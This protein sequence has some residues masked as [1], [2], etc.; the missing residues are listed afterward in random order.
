MLYTSADLVAL[1]QEARN[2][3]HETLMGLPI[4]AERH[5]R[6]RDFHDRTFDFQVSDS[7]AL[8]VKPAK[9]SSLATEKYTTGIMSKPA[10]VA[11]AKASHAAPTTEYQESAL[12]IDEE[13]AQMRQSGDTRSRDALRIVVRNQRQAKK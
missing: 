12:S 3:N 1:L 6:L 5:D 13:V 7:V 10:K 2:L 11:K 9:R 4:T 8:E